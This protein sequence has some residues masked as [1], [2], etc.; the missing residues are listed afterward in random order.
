MRKTCKQASDMWKTGE[1]YNVL[2]NEMSD[3]VHGRRFR[4]WHDVVG[5]ASPEQAAE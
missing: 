4:T 3:V 5:K 2:P 1:L